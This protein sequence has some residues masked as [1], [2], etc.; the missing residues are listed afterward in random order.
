MLKGLLPL[1]VKLASSRSYSDQLRTLKLPCDFET[2]LKTLHQCSET[3][4][5]DYSLGLFL[6]LLTS[7]A[8]IS[9]N[10]RLAKSGF[11]QPHFDSVWPYGARWVILFSP[12]QLSRP[13]CFSVDASNTDWKISRDCNFELGVTDEGVRER[14]A[15][16][17][18]G[19]TASTGF[20]F[21]LLIFMAVYF[22]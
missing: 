21:F 14:L 13:V 5:S 15:L 6:P 2:T 4:D 11:N 9:G 10:D 19:D 1:D 12:R 20:G 3:V 17:R 16:T 7:S 8:Y 18:I 22:E